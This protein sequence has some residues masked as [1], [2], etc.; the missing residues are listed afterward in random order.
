MCEAAV[1]HWRT[2]VEI[3]VKAISTAIRREILKI[4]EQVIIPFPGTV[5][6]GS[7]IELTGKYLVERTVVTRQQ[8]SND[9]V[10]NVFYLLSDG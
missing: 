7:V 10:A 1:S 5:L 8:D 4:V 2:P 9:S 3:F 6:Y